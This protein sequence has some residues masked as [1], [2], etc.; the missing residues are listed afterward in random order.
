M[1]YN[2]QT[3]AIFLKELQERG[4]VRRKSCYKNE[5]FGYWKSFGEIMSEI[6]AVD[7]SSEENN[8]EQPPACQYQI[9][10]LIYDF[11]GFA[12]H[13]DEEFPIKVKYEFVIGARHVLDMASASIA[14]EKMTVKWF[15][16]FCRELYDKLFEGFLFE[17]QKFVKW[18]ATELLKKINRAL[19]I[20][21]AQKNRKRLYVYARFIFIHKVKKNTS[22]N[23]VEIGNIIGK[24]HASV[25]HALK[26]YE[27]L[28]KYPDFNKIRNKINNFLLED[29]N[30]TYLV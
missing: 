5:S 30:G 28:K 6:S 20:D 11:S 9:A 2:Q 1:K 15:E 8:V 4:Y 3:L 29:N 24:D 27:K 22:L 12:M 7:G 14:D 17:K 13:E 19:G 23:L 25:I 10:I 21:I 26:E 16:V 18:E